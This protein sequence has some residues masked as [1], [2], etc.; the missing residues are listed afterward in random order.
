[1]N[2]FWKNALV[3]SLGELAGTAVRVLP[4]PKPDRPALP[5]PPA[6]SPPARRRQPRV[7]GLGGSSGLPPEWK[8]VPA[9]NLPGKAPSGAKGA[10][11]CGCSGGVK[12]ALSRAK[13]RAV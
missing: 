10:G 11:D 4:A 6:P 1:M 9:R 3:E 2:T 8:R 12:K 13:A 7:E 5:A